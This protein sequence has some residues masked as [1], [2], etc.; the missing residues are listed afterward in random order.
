MRQIERK[1][2]FTLVE[3]LVVIAI[4]GILIAL[5]LP[6]V[7]AARSAARR[8][9]CK[10]NMKQIGLAFHNYHGANKRFPYAAVDF[11][12]DKT[13]SQIES[14]C[15]T[16][17]LP[18]LE[19]TA[20]ANMYDFKLDWW[21]R[22]NQP[23]I[24]TIVP[25]FICPEVGEDGRSVPAGGGIADYSISATITNGSP[26]GALQTMQARGMD[27][28]PYL[29]GSVILGVLQPK[30]KSNPN[31]TPVTFKTIT[32]GTS[33]TF[34]FFEDVGRP[35]FLSD[36]G[37]VP[38]AKAGVNG[39]SGPAWASPQNWYVTHNYPMF[40][41]HNDNEIYSTH[42]GGAMF[43]YCDGSVHF[44]TTSISD[45]NFCARFTPNK[46]DQVGEDF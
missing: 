37:I 10:N 33:K 15:H 11:G 45:A 39:V 28:K 20:T 40:N 26:I 34:L 25:T 8:T 9:Q 4:I 29:T 36:P 30:N 44:I 16:F 27:L 6:A 13:S 32:D 14:S 41:Y 19:E 1:R 24:Q 5:L 46:G 3:L 2:G 35:K 43:L 17:L 7:Q 12:N 31:P 23:A 18:F 42:S 21:D 38:T 22:A